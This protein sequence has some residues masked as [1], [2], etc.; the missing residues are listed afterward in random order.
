MWGRNLKNDAVQGRN[1]CLSAW[2]GVLS[3]GLPR[4]PLNI[5][6]YL[7]ANKLFSL[8]KWQFSLCPPP[9]PSP[10]SIPVLSCVQQ[11]MVSFPCYCFW[12]IFHK[13]WIQVYTETCA[14][15][16]A[17]CILHTAH[18][19]GHTVHC[20]LHTAQGTLQTVQC[21]VHTAHS[22]LHPAQ[23]TLHT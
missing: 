22:T 2:K 5:H 19:T 9:P 16:T 18:C 1:F 8:P 21:T 12:I 23:C 20:T 4:L 3:E 13:M 7:I 10:L 6:Q 15:H 14:L 11:I 17:Q